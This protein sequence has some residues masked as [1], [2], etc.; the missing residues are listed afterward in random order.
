MLPFDEPFVPKQKPGEYVP[1]PVD[2]SPEAVAL[3]EKSAKQVAKFDK[4]RREEAAWRE[5]NEICPW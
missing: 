5:F 3:R 1:L 4:E 2:M